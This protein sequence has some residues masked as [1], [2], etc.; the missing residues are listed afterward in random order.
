MSTVRLGAPAGTGAPVRQ[1]WQGLSDREAR[2]RLARFGPN[3]LKKERGPGLL[4]MFIEQ[5]QEILVLL[6]IAAAAVSALAGEWVDATVIMA[7]V[8]VNAATGVVQEFRAERALTALREMAAPS[9]RVYRQGLWKTVP[10]CEIVPGDL[11][12]VEAG[13]RVPADMEIVEALNL[14]VDESI[15]TGE[16]VAVEKDGTAGKDLLFASTTVVYG[17]CKGY[18][19]RTGMGTRVGLL[20]KTLG[21]SQD[22]EPPLKRKLDV[23]GQ[24]LAVACLALVAITFLIGVLRGEWWL[25]M[26]LASVSLGVAAIPEGLPAI[27]T[28]VLA[29][30]TRR[31]SRQNAV[32]RKLA[33]V[34]TLGSVTVVCSDKT[35]TLTR[36]EMSVT[37]IF[38]G[39]RRYSVSGTGYSPE[40]EIAPLEG[41]GDSGDAGPLERL[42]IAGLLAS[43]ALL[44]EGKK[45]WHIMG[46]PT[47]GALVVAAAK[48]GL[49]R[50]HCE[51]LYPRVFE[52]PFDSNRKMMTTLHLEGVPRGRATRYVSFTKGAPD[53]VLAK[54]TRTVVAGSVVPLNE[55]VRQVYAAVSTEMAGRALRVLAVATREWN[56]EGWKNGRVEEDLTFLG[57]FGMIDPPRP[58][59]ILAVSTCRKAGVRPVMVTGDQAPT[60]LAVARQLG[61]AGG[62]TRPV[63]GKDIDSMDDDELVRAA[64]TAPVYAQVSPEHK[65][66]IVTA[67]KRD[68]HI[69]AM[70]GD[71]VN[72][73]PALKWADIGI[74]MGVK[75]TDVA[76]EASDMILAD[77]NFA[78]IIKAI[79]EGR[80]IYANV[81]K[82]IRYLLSCNTGELI[83][84][85]GAILCGFGRPLLAAQILWVNLATDAAPAIALG[86][87]KPEHD[88]ITTAPPDPGQGIFT[89]DM[90]WRIL[91]EGLWIGCISLGTYV[92]VLRSGGPVAHARSMCFAVLTFSQLF[93]ANNCRSHH[94]SL[95]KL[96]AF[97]SLPMVVAVALSSV[98]Q[99]LAMVGPLRVMFGVDLLS[100]MEWCWVLTASATMI[101]LAEVMKNSLP[102]EDALGRRS[103]AGH[104]RRPPPSNQ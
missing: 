70:T 44:Q 45:G 9:A 36:N 50:D 26:F 23:V 18:V 17:R 14:K 72:D 91:V 60:A 12:A 53:R 22:E 100:A 47:E 57:Y 104:N 25:E 90:T 20:A 66:R 62:G 80:T 48:A 39:G 28:V 56:G 33:S 38:C 59:A 93:H 61:I 74:A 1:K 19:T 54:C 52:I 77:D 92:I 55:A 102:T 34:E 79:T 30:G 35:G 21:E 101:P 37:E 83:T 84:V 8:I 42:L 64:R 3:E 10:S 71:G 43:D 5:F 73:A 4:Q 96:G 86:M 103:P 98:I 85:V 32:V 69:V 6:L 63:V 11:V 13:D 78:T 40:G 51:S 82:S 88:V 41:E 99:A 15:L 16:S 97:S 46:D 89:W 58:E 27:V 67:L 76:K 81:R 24:N 68:R 95:F 87:E 65:V 49:S 94:Q 31:M 75:G 2:R 7:I 29:I